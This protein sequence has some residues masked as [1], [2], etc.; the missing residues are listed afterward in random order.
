M[1][2]KP[3][4]HDFGLFPAVLARGFDGLGERNGLVAGNRGALFGLGQTG[5]T[6]QLGVVRQFGRSAGAG[7]KPEREAD[8]EDDGKTGEDRHKA[9]DSGAPVNAG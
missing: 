4:A 8:Q 7:E 2:A 5:V 9:G 1:A 6:R 3:R